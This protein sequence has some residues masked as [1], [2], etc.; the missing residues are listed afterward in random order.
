MNSETIVALRTRG[1]GVV[2]KTPSKVPEVVQYIQ[3]KYS[4]ASFLDAENPEDMG[5]IRMILGM[6]NL[7]V[8]VINNAQS[9]PTSLLEDYSDWMKLMADEGE[10]TVKIVLLGPVVATLL[11]RSPDLAL[12]MTVL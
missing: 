3:Q 10:P 7:G 8:V 5:Y 2:V 4:T 6:K 1:R 9:M 11:R 12:R